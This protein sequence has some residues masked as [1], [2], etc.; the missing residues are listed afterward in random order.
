[1]SS[2][3]VSQ[4]FVATYCKLSSASTQQAFDSVQGIIYHL[5]VT[6][7]ITFSVTATITISQNYHLADIFRVNLTITT[8]H[9]LYYNRYYRYYHT[10]YS[11]FI[12]ITCSCYCSFYYYIKLLLTVTITNA[13]RPTISDHLIYY[14]CC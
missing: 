11:L 5:K 14:C 4:C 3:R 13:A 9:S 12:P 2:C 10:N 1:M 8:S 6:I 7:T